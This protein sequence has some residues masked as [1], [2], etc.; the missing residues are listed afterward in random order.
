LLSAALE[1]SATD[2][3]SPAAWMLVAGVLI[4]GLAGIIALSRTGMRLFWSVEDSVTPRLRV[5]EA[6]PVGVLILACVALAFWAGPV[7][8]YLE[9]TAKYLDQ[10]SAYINA[11]L[12]QNPMRGIAPGALP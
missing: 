3:P 8:S 12:T 2:T 10:P 6:G 9:E 5:I 4:S 11:V 1:T 7:M